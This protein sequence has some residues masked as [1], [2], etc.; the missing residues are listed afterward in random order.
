MSSNTFI[1]PV[2]DTRI[3]VALIAWFVVCSITGWLASRKDR[4][5]GFWFVLAMFSGPLAPLTLLV[6]A[7][8]PRGRTWEETTFGPDPK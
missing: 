7:L 5:G 6:L 8:M 1:W 3:V 2:L 4:D